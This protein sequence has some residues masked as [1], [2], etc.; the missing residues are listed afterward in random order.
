MWRRLPRL[1]VAAN[2][3]LSR[4]EIDIAVAPFQ[5][6]TGLLMHTSYRCHMKLLSQRYAGNH[7]ACEHDLGP[8]VAWQRLI[9]MTV[10]PLTT[11]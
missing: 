8:P 9:I 6:Q 1:S 2:L 7:V 3:L 5:T 10:P 11:G 4:F